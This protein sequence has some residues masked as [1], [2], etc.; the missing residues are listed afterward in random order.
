MIKWSRRRPALAALI[1][2]GAMAAIT[3]AVVIGVANVRLELAARDRAEAKG[4]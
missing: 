3:L 2:T 1:G 4:A